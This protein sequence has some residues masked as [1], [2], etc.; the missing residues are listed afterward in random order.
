MSVK[1][2][3]FASS[4]KEYTAAAHKDLEAVIDIMTR[5]LTLEHYK[6][7]L[8]MMGKFIGS[9]ET[10]LYLITGW[11]AINLNLDERL[12]MPLILKDYDYLKI[13]N[14]NEPISTWAPNYPVL[15]SIAAGLGY[16]YVLEGA[17][18]GARF[19]APHLHRQLGLTATAGA[20]YYH[21]YGQE[22][23]SKWQEFCEILN[24]FAEHNPDLQSD[25]KGAAYA[26]FD[27]LTQG[28]KKEGGRI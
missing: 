23:V 10:Q 24:A 12:K 9:M 4:L 15:R 13:Y 5:E 7:I 28:F 6:Y 2:P 3:N 19:I 14:P 11:Q 25:I 26:T 18:L 22:T 20:N 16:L 21:N 1:S 17:T 8:L 27:S